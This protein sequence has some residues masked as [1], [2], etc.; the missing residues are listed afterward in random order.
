MEK[1]FALSGL[2]HLVLSIDCIVYTLLPY[3]EEVLNKDLE[4]KRYP[5]QKQ[6]FNPY[7]TVMILATHL[8]PTTYF[9]GYKYVIII[10]LDQL[11]NNFNEDE[12]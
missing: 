7:Q 8:R 10:P 5:L 4:S 9:N 3:V 11:Q 2:I 6:V 1:H 12:Y